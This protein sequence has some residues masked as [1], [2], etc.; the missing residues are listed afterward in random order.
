MAAGLE[1]TRRQRAKVF[2]MLAPTMNVRI[3]LLAFAL[4]LPSAALADSA[5][6]FNEIMYHPLTNEPALE[7]VELQNQHAV[8]IDL[9]G[10]RLDGGID[11]N[12]A[13][14]TVLRGGGY[15]VVAS[16]PAELTAATGLTNVAGPFRNRLSNV[17]DTLRLRNNDSRII[18]EVSYGGEGD[19]PV[20]PDGAGPTLARRRANLRSADPG[21]WRAS[22]QAGGTPGAENFPIRPPTI[23]SNTL[24]AIEGGW[25]FNDTGTDLGT[26]WRAPNFDDSSWS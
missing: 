21:S 1:E 16:A 17:G 2:R 6:V 24:V 26:A 13:E 9:S 10:W 4:A 7:W 5:V 18:D 22:A 11:F 25:K 23:L 8:D 19:W 15:L 3:V 12:F 14:G 20:A